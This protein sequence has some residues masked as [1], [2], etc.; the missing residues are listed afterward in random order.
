[1]IITSLWIEA[2][3]SMMGFVG[4]SWALI[5][6]KDKQY[7]VYNAAKFVLSVIALI[8]ILN[9]ILLIG[10]FETAYNYAFDLSIGRY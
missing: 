9:M 5:S 1:M 8:E 4:A 10:R 7:F 2:V 6:L 3:L